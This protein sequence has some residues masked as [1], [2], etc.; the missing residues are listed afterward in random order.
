MNDE[1]KPVAVFNGGHFDCRFTDADVD[2]LSFVFQMAKCADIA[3]ARLAPLTEALER[4][5]DAWAG[6]SIPHEEEIAVD[7]VLAAYEALR[8]GDGT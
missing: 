5:A 1:K 4:L 8:K 7:A 3:N 2:N 6:E